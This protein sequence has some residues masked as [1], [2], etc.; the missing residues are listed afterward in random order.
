LDVGQ[1]KGAFFGTRILAPR[2]FLQNLAGG[3]SLL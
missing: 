2:V 1:Y 3:L